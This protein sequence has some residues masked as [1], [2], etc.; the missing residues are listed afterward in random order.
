MTI[1]DNRPGLA[2]RVGWTI[3]AIAMA[4]ACSLMAMNW[5]VDLGAAAHD[6]FCPEHG[7]LV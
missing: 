5:M 1:G 3:A 7:R 4:G 2:D 6:A